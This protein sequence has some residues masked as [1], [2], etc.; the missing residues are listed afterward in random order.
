MGIAAP[1]LQE[2]P[3]TAGHTGCVEPVRCVEPV[4]SDRPAGSNGC[5]K[6]Q[7]IV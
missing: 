5:G 2:S 4:F 1:H 7:L 6:A 3:D